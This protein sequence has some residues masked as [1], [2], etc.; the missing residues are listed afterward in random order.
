MGVDAMEGC[1]DGLDACTRSY[2]KQECGKD[3]I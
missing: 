3:C 2:A 1:P